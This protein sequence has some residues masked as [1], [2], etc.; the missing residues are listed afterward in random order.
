MCGRWYYP[1]TRERCGG[2][3]I[4]VGDLTCLWRASPNPALDNSPI[5]FNQLLLNPALS[6]A[7]CSMTELSWALSNSSIV[8][9]WLWRG[10]VCWMNRPH[11]HGNQLWLRGADL[12]PTC[13]HHTVNYWCLWVEKESQGN[14]CQSYCFSL[15]LGPGSTLGWHKTPILTQSSWMLGD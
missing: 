3:V 14:G 10:S 1:S 4:R 5:L 2:I 6:S 12:W 13:C 11:L 8:C 15:S 7:L 9:K